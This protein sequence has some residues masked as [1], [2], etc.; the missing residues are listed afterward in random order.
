[1]NRNIEAHGQQGKKTMDNG[2]GIEMVMMASI[3]AMFYFSMV[4]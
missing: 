4:N 2:K 3:L 1:M